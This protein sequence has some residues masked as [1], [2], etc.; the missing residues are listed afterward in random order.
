MASA[1]YNAGESHGQAQANTEQWVDSGKSIANSAVDKA[2]NATQ[3]ASETAE[4][5]KDQN[6]GFLQQTGEQMIHMAQGAI[7]GVKNTLGMGSDK[8]QRE[9]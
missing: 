4:Q 7:D 2:E 8:K 3:R 1:Q 5:N 9:N 6:S